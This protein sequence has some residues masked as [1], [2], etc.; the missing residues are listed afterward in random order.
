MPV[1]CM[2]INCSKRAKRDKGIKFFRIPAVIKHQG[3]QMEELSDERRRL[4]KKAISVD[5]EFTEFDRVCS[6]H[7]VNGMYTAIV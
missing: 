2:V 6:C 1:S 5:R 3:P 4:W 7:F